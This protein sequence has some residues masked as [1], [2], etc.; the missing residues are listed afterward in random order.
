MT[1]GNFFYKR[2]GARIIAERKK[3]GFTQ[4]QLALVSD[5]DR[6][7]MARMEEGK[8]NPTI[9]IL[10]KMCKKLKI[11]ISKLLKGV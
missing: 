9:K 1:R 4:E 5:I 2:V 3:K 11:C 6:T 10:Y 7:Y 8:A